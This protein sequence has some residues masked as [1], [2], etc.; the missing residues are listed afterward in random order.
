MEFNAVKMGPTLFWRIPFQL[1]Q[2]PL[3]STQIKEH[4]N[5]IIFLI[6]LSSVMLSFL[7]MMSVVSDVISGAA[8]KDKQDP[9]GC[10]TVDLTYVSLHSPVCLFPA[11]SGLLDPRQSLLPSLKNRVERYVQASKAAF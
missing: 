5:K 6:S 2:F 7:E 10:W 3:F 9:G 4:T 11:F 1:A 8:S